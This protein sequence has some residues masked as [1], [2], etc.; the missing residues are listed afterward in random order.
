MYIS[1]L[2]YPSIC[3]CF[4]SS[5][6]GHLG[7]FHVLAIWIGCMNI[8]KWSDVK[9]LSR[10]RLFATLWTVAYQAPLSMGF[11]RQG[12]CSGLPF[13]SPGIF[14]TQGSNL[15]LPHC[16][17]TLYCLSHEGS[18]NMNIGAQLNPILFLSF[19]L[20]HTAYGI[21]VPHP[22]I[23]PRP[24]P[25]QWKHQVLTG[26]PGNSHESYFYYSEDGKK[27]P[28]TNINTIKPLNK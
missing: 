19:W 21:S 18:P 13:P 7:C 22:G 12:Y 23:E 14:P 9:S 10:V 11:S 27:I 5:V 17:Q 25:W 20:H 24:S 4:C 1:H 8:V 6:D 3:F 2:L 15:G 26:S 16:R 28:N